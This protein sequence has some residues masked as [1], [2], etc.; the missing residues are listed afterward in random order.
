MK[1][2]AKGLASTRTIKVLLVED[3]E[4]VL[5]GLGKLIDGEWPKMMVIGT[6]RNMT[7][8]AVMMR[9]RN[10]DVVVL[11]ACLGEHDALD[12]LPELLASNRA[13]VLVWTECNDVERQCRA[14]REGAQAV[15]PKDAPAE[16]L[17]REIERVHMWRAP[18]RDAHGERS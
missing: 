17:L 9:D 1:K 18:A 7:D 15:V 12:R 3:H 8:A 13:K 16:L 2:A 14:L 5:W 4:H 11:D 10:P 6:A